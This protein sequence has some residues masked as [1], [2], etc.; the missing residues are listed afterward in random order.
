MKPNLESVSSDDQHSSV[1]EALGNLVLVSNREPYRHRH[2]GAAVTVDTPAGGLAIGMDPVMRRIDGTWIA[3]GDGDADFETVDDE[4]QVRVPPDEPAYTL[5]RLDLS[6]EAVAGYYDGYANQALWPLCHS[7][8]EHVR[9]E[10]DHWRQYHAVNETFADAVLAHVDGDTPIWFQDYHLMLAPRLVRERAPDSF[11]FHFFHVPWPAPDVFR[12]CP[13][14]TAL[15][16]G[17]LGNDLLGF[18]RPRYVAQFLQSVDQLLDDAVV[19]WGT[20]TVI[21]RGQRTH[22]EAV[23]FSVDADDIRQTAADADGGFWQ[24]FRRE[25]GIDPN[26]TVGLGVDRLDYTKGIPERLATLDHLF[27]TR[28]ALR[29]EFTYVQKG[30]ETR[31]HVP[32]YRQLRADI[33]TTIDEINEQYGTEEWQPVV[34]TTAMYDRANLIALYRHSD[35]AIVSP[36]RDG[37]NLVAKEYVAAQVDNDGVLL[38][39]PLTGAGG[40]LTEGVVEFDP[41]QKG[42]AADAIERALTMSET[43][44]TARMRTL[45]RQVHE[46]DL[47]WWLEEIVTTVEQIRGERAEP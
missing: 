36:V 44:R 19:D 45:R 9:F 23:P 14:A 11:L 6:P 24:Q 34:Y 17:L 35:L 7:M 41:Y 16:D 40:Q 21:Y 3:W 33:E 13:Q 20:S 32:A 37:M 12:I 29:G 42:A 30:C 25:H 43:E 22:V 38:L 2:E 46:T 10:P 15:L 26:V 8:L 39:S 4:D 27:E 1:A 47:S 18:H 31:E 28:P 5:Q